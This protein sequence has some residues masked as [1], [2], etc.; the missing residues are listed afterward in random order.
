MF[1]FLMFYRYIHDDVFHPPNSR[2][3][4]SNHVPAVPYSATSQTT[5]VSTKGNGI[6]KKVSKNMSVQKHKEHNDTMK[7]KSRRHSR[8]SGETTC[9]KQNGDVKQK[10]SLDRLDITTYY[11]TQSPY[12]D[13]YQLAKTH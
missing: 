6:R 12:M 8:H 1:T 10:Q 2:P 13:P 3:L 11:G 4:P 7:V 5:H 9:S